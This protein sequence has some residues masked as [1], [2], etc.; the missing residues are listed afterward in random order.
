MGLVHLGR[1]WWNSLLKAYQSEDSEAKD[2]SLG[3][4]S[5]LLSIDVHWKAIGSPDFTTDSDSRE[6]LAE[7]AEYVAADSDEGDSSAPD[8][9]EILAKAALTSHERLVVEEVV[10]KKRKAKDVAARLNVS[11]GPSLPT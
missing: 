9:D 11:P 1:P 7:Y 4:L 10:L 6:I 8:L 5:S 3:K 2:V